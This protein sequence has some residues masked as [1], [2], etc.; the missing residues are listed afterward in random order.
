ML[1]PVVAKI[2]YQ[3]HVVAKELNSD[4]VNAASGC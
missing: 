2:S 1:K 4:Y 3:V